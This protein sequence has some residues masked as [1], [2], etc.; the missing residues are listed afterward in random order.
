MP[1]PT[2][3][4]LNRIVAVIY[5]E[6][7]LHGCIV[8]MHADGQSTVV[9][10]G[11]SPSINFGR[12]AVIIEML[13]ENSQLVNQDTRKWADASGGS[14]EG[15]PNPIILNKSVWGR[16]AVGA[17]LSCGFAVVAA[18]GV[19]G[20]VAAEVPT[21]GTSTFLLVASWAGL[22]TAGI[23]C[24]NGVVRVGAIIANPDG[25][26]L[27]RAD[28]NSVY[29]YSMLLVD[30]IGVASGIAGLGA[31]G[32]NL[33]A[34]MARQRSFAARNL[35]EEA[36]KNMNRAE[37]ARVIREVLEEASQTAEGKR[38]IMDVAKAVSIAEKTLAREGSLSVRNASAMVKII[39][40]ETT[41]RLHGNLVG[42]FGTLAGTA[43]S[44]SPGEYTGS[45]SGS[46]NWL[47]NLVDLGKGQSI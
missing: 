39:G 42:I 21:A 46:V 13:E 45:A 26:S 7:E 28:E 12:V 17:G 18:V 22:V 47:I 40:E 25:N 24:V 33:W 15:T 36:L 43:A 1:S 29:K 19:A 8:G 5:R 38:A 23:Q 44:A 27:Q 37:R 6:K 34:V 3:D 20:S 2:R 4:Q 16:E 9:S 31:A 10:E 30:A 14:P 41:K 35:T 11:L 32:K